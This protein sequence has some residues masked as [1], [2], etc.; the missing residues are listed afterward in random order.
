MSDTQ[1]PRYE[2]FEQERPDGPHRNAGSVH[3][4]DA[5]MALENARDVFVRRPECLSIWVAPARAIFAKTAQELAENNSWQTEASPAT[6][7]PETYLV[8]QKR[9]Q[10]ATETYVTHVGEV[11]ARTPQA[12]LVLALEKFDQADVFV[13]WVC[14]ARAITRNDPADAQSLFT[15]AHDKPFRQPNFYKVLTQM[16]ENRN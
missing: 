14:P 12:A 6:A 3:A 9:T 7:E 11:A 10:R 5:E 1:W 13:W 4:A 8:F 16:R 15:P 2:V